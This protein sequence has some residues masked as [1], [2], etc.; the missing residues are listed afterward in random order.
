LKHKN[1]E[2]AVTIFAFQIKFD[3]DFCQKKA[4][5]QETKF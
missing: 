4:V 1:L 5:S 2:L 3:A